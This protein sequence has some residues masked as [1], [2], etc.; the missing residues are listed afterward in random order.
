MKADTRFYMQNSK[1]GFS[2]TELIVVLGIF[3][4][5][6]TV[7]M[8]RFSLFNNQI[9]T[10]NLAYDIALS[11]REAQSYGTN[12]RGFDPGGGVIFDAGYGVHFDES[13]NNS[14]IFFADLNQNKEY[15]N[16]ELIDL[17]TIGGGHTIKRFCGAVGGVED[18]NTD[19]P[20]WPD[21]L[22]IVFTRPSP[23]AVI[24]T[25]GP[26]GLTKDYE[27]GTIVI[28]STQ[29]TEREIRVFST[30]QISIVR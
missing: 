27:V 14:Y 5:I 16:G 7:V 23:D 2:L 30:G 8:V 26:P 17:V 10:T 24:R 28:T 19:A 18:C 25:H 22:D 12:V 11:I 4:T 13:S 1:R 3:V 20:P 9:L 21:E 15:D 6:T 29:G